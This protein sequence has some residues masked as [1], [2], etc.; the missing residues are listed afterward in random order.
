MTA[1][2]KDIDAASTISPVHP[3]PDNE[4]LAAW[5]VMDRAHDA[6]D[7]RLL[8]DVLGLSASDALFGRYLARHR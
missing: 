7:A 5:V 4:A 6:A 8:L 2:G 1:V 3:E